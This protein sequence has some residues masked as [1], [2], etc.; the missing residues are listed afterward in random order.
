M[1]RLQA[2][3]ARSILAGLLS[4]GLLVTA[5]PGQAAAQSVGAMRP[6]L[7]ASVSA[8]PGTAGARQP[9]TY[10]ATVRNIGLVATRD[11][12]TGGTLYFNTPASGVVFQQ[13]L[14]AGAVFQSA[15]GDSG[16][17]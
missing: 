8:S 4:I 17:G 14:P 13:T 3:F 9:V 5:A 6:D 1:K 2:R 10:T 15:S 7:A 11:P 12:F 16:F